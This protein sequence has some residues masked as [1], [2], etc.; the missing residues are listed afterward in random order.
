[1]TDRVFMASPR[2]RSI[3]LSGVTT[4]AMIMVTAWPMWSGAG[5][6]VA[7]AASLGL[8]ELARLGQGHAKWSHEA[9]CHKQPMVEK[10]GGVA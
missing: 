3:D 9:R 8:Y 4:L 1:M 7:A 5:L 6:G 10:R 2:I